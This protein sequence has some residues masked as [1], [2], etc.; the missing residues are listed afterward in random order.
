[1]AYI[2]LNEIGKIKSDGGDYLLLV[3]YGCEGIAVGS[4]H[5]SLA[6]AISSALYG[7]NNPQ[8]IVKIV[9]IVEPTEVKEK[10]S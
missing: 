8:A 3:D 1:M 9:R 4:Q 6:S 5:T 2:A 7:S 10:T